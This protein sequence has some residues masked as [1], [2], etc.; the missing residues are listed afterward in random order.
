MVRQG[1][2]VVE[3]DARPRSQTPV[4]ERT[5]SKLR[6]V[7]AHRLRVQLFI[8]QVELGQLFTERGEGAEVGGEREARQFALQV[9]RELRPVAGMVLRPGGETR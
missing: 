4:W 9:V 1:V 8:V 5:S 3:D 6:F 2:E 7:R